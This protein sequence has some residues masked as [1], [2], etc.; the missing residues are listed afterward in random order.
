MEQGQNQNNHYIITLKILTICLMTVFSVPVSKPV[1]SVVGGKLVLGK[2]FQML[3]HSDSG[4]LPIEYTLFG[5]KPSVQSVVRKPGEQAIFNVSA[6]YKR[7]D[8]NVFLCHAKN[9]QHK[10]PM[11]SQQQLH[12]STTVIGVLDALTFTTHSIKYCI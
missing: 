9:S 5:Q 1:L 10:P 6:I 12:R 11:V 2:S 3:C 4:T 7:S 8:I